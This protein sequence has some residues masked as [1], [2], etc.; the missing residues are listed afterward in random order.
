[1]TE[2]TL[3]LLRHAKSDWPAGVPDVERPLADRGR[4]DAPVA[5][6]LLARLVGSFDLALVSP[7]TRTQQTWML[8]GERV[9]AD[10]VVLEPAIYDASVHD[11]LTLVRA[12]PDSSD[13]T[14]LIG[15]NPGIADLTLLLA[16][17]GDAHARERIAQKFPT[18]GV[19]VLHVTGGWTE[20]APGSATLAGFH[21]PRAGSA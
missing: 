16:G 7:A 4:S 1:M 20:I 19:A 11:L 8:V 9:S 18:C 10:E 13:T 15:H 21:I 14:L 2:R 17:D 3:V 12:I 6:D 5:G